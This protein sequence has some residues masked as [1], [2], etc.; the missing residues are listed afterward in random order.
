MEICDVLGTLDG[1]VE[2]SYCLVRLGEVLQPGII[3]LT[4]LDSRRH[5]GCELRG[6]SSHGIVI[7]LVI[8]KEYATRVVSHI[9]PIVLGHDAFQKLD[10][11]KT[12]VK[13]R[14]FSSRLA[15]HLR[16]NPLYATV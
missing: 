3:A 7:F 12:I 8:I 2:L 10:F 11:V 13:N 5:R 6:V 4:V 9:V 1:R 16:T 15:M 14:G